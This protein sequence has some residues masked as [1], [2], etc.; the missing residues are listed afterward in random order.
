[1]GCEG[2][3]RGVTAQHTHSS[4]ELASWAEQPKLKFQHPH[5]LCG[6]GFFFVGGHF[7]ELVATC[8]PLATMMTATTAIVALAAISFVALPSVPPGRCQPRLDSYCNSAALTDCKASMEKG[9]FNT[10]L[11]ARCASDMMSAVV[12][13]CTRTMTVNVSLSLVGL[14]WL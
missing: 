9:H 5:A 12:V 13:G 2:L 7:P 10:S 6:V 14:C 4:K 8:Q 1:V 11:V 3:S